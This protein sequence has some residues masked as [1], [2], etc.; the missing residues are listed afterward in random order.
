MRGHTDMVMDLQSLGT[1]ALLASAGLDSKIFFWD[2]ITNKIHQEVTGHTKVVQ[3]SITFSLWA[4]SQVTLFYCTAAF[5]VVIFFFF[6]PGSSF[7][8]LLP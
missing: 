3:Q 8:S 6:R 5:V 2:M 7:V 1:T 4:E